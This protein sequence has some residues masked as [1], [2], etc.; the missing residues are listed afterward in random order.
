MSTA[1]QAAAPD[2]G[3]LDRLRTELRDLRARARVRPLISELQQ[4]LH[5]LISRAGAAA[6]RV[7]RHGGPGPA[8]AGGRTGSQASD[9]R[10]SSDDDV[11]DAEFD[12]S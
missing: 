1:G 5:G 11:V 7:P 9:T 8:S 3:E 6:G 10:P 12:R 2:D 4:V